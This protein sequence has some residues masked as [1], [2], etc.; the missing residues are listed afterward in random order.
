MPCCLVHQ[1]EESRLSWAGDM[2]GSTFP[3]SFE[4]CKCGVAMEIVWNS[5][6]R[7]RHLVSEDWAAGAS[8]TIDPLPPQGLKL[9][10]SNCEALVVADCDDT[11]NSCPVSLP[12]DSVSSSRWCEIIGLCRSSISLGSKY[13][14]VVLFKSSLVRRCNLLLSRRIHCT[15]RH[16]MLHCGLRW[17]FLLLWSRLCLPFE[18]HLYV[19]IDDK[20]SGIFYHLCSRELHR[21]EM[22]VVELSS[23]LYWL[24]MRY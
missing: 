21:S 7:L 19:R 22:A 16:A 17:H 8:S 13:A 1:N 24:S 5:S 12:G 10:G 23:L 11:L 20:W 4:G 14:A 9:M 2:S 18:R 15:S 3:E 6:L